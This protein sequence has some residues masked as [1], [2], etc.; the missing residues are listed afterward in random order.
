[1]RRPCILG[2]FLVVLVANGW[3]IRQSIRN[4]ADSRGGTL[5]LTEREL[6]L[7][8][9]AFESSVSVLRLHWRTERTRNGRFGSAAWLDSA[10]LASLGFDCSVP[11]NSPKAQRHYSSMPPRRA[12]LALEYQ[13]FP[14]PDAAAPRRE[15]TGLVVVDADQSA[16]HLRERYAD[17]LKY[18]VCRGIVR[19][20]LT[21]RDADGV[22]LSTPRLEGRV[23]GLAP[24]RVSVPR[25]ANRLLVPFLRT[26]EEAGNTPAGEP[27]FSARVHWGRN[28]EPWVDD[29]RTLDSSP[30]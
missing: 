13:E 22:L 28:Y 14:R 24:S 3:G 1:M 7:E 23:L 16:E 29:V 6:S 5:Q 11:L 9:V 12:F 2:A 17:P 19:I 18:S 15:R 25:P 30:R 10:K 8:P 27:R 20:T 21:R 26:S 4:R